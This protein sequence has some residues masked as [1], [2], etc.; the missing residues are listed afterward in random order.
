MC[1]RGVEIPPGIP[2]S[3]GGALYLYHIFPPFKTLWASIWGGSFAR[4][5]FYSPLGIFPHLYSFFF[6]PPPLFVGG[7][8]S[9]ISGGEISS[10]RGCGSHLI[11]SPL[12]TGRGGLLYPP[13]FWV[14]SP[15]SR[16]IALRGG[17][18]SWCLK[19]PGVLLLPGDFPPE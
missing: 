13:L 2:L 1:L 11:N 14:V 4:G 9:H 3:G 12:P 10:P 7:A 5:L 6:S 8:L 15:L 19:N 18:T 17:S 16:F